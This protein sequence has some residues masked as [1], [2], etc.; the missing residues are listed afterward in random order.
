[1]KKEF[2]WE[3]VLSVEGRKGAATFMSKEDGVDADVE[4]SRIIIGNSTP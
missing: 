1:M 2:R 4:R 3:L